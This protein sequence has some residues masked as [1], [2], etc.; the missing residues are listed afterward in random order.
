MFYGLNQWIPHSFKRRR[1]WLFELFHELL[2]SCPIE[3]LWLRKILPNCALTDTLCS[4]PECYTSMECSTSCAP[5]CTRNLAW[6]RI[7]RAMILVESLMLVILFMRI[8]GWRVG[9]PLQ[10]GRTLVCVILV[11]SIRFKVRLC[12]SL[13]MIL[14]LLVFP[15]PE[16]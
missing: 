1:L 11:T 5:S 10:T 8:D 13:S 2:Q 14:V 4:T 3:C 6:K 15:C 16:L 7:H 12:S 9:G